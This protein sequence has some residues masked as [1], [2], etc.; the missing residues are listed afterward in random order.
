MYSSKLV[1]VFY[2][3]SKTQLRALRKFVRSP[4]HNKRQDVIDLFDLMYKT[5]LDNRIALRK[6]KVFPKL[7][8]KEPYSADKIDYTMS[9][10]FKVIEQFLIHQRVVNNSTKS[11]MILAE[12]YLDLGLSKHFQQTLKS[13]EQNLQKDTLRDIMYH[14]QSFL[15]ESQKHSF[16]SKQQRNTSINLQEVSTKLE[17]H[18]LAQKLKKT[19]LM[20]A[21]QAVY[22]KQ[23]D[24]GLLDLL[25]PYI[26]EHP[27]LLE[28][29]A[30]SIYYYYYQSVTNE[31]E[32]EAYFQKFKSIF[33]ESN[34]AFNK[35]ELEDI[36]KFAL[37]YCIKKVNTGQAEYLQELFEFYNVGLEFSILFDANNKLSP[38]T[39][40]NIT[41]LA[42]RLHKIDWTAEFIEKYQHQVEEQYHGTYVHNAYSMLYFSQGKYQETMVRLQQLDAKE[43]FIT[44]DAKVLLCK[45]YYHLEEYDVLESFLNSFKVFLRR[46]DI[47][48]YHK[49]NY[50]N[51]IRFT[52]KLISL[53]PFDKAER[54]KLRTDAEGTKKLLEK[55]WL[56]E[57]LT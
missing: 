21:R 33:L 29:K 41:K 32:N 44:L 30:I 31:H 8:G 24:F 57:Q 36:Y 51:F 42:L 9:F 22:K 11:K 55:T 34:E 16:L 18:F 47:L 3:L 43:L 28:H 2:T 1:D 25:L 37:N 49:E 39:F 6:E 35:K 54:K 4:Y 45:V 38:F 12:S 23:Y 26:E 50:K 53:P 10:L 52:Q 19:C 13:V 17:L 27:K 20:L 56:L 40:N 46:K 7:F 5:P 15:I 48:A 14:E